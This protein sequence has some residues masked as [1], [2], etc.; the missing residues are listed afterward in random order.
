[1]KID[2]T[3][4]TVFALFYAIM[5]GR[6]LNRLS[7]WSVF[8]REDAEVNLSCGSSGFPV[9]ND[10][11]QRRRV[12]REFVHAMIFAQFSLR[13]PRLGGEISEYYFTQKPQEPKL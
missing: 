2:I 5:F 3:T 11:P 9:K 4:T 8:A 13:P 1:M 7:D 10:S 6:I 12:H